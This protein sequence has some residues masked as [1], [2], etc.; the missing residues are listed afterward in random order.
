[1]KG[2]FTREAAREQLHFPVRAVAAENRSI[3]VSE[4]TI[5]ETVV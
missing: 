5:V 3:A 4:I 2:V 1:M